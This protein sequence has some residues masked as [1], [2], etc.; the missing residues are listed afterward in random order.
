[1]GNAHLG[2]MVAAV[3]VGLLGQF[4]PQG[5]PDG[6]AGIL[7]CVVMYFVLSWVLMLFQV[8]VERAYVFLARPVTVALALCCAFAE[9]PPPRPQSSEFPQG[10]RVRSG[11]ERF[12][13]RFVLVLERVGSATASVGGWWSLVGPWFGQAGVA[14]I[15]KGAGSSLTEWV[16]HQADY[17]RYFTAT[18]YLVRS[19]LKH[20]VESLVGRAKTLPGAEKEMKDKSA[21]M[22]QASFRQA[23]EEGKFEGSVTE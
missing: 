10:F 14:E 15:T 12:D 2:I 17:G 11:M 18:G 16:V 7:G 19:A 8:Y 9:A 6:S 21:R 1:M 20:D 22:I 3:A 4:W 5:F 13:S 23:R